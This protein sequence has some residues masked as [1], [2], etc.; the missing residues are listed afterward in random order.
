MN[1]IHPTLHRVLAGHF[2]LHVERTQIDDLPR[3]VVPATA[4]LY[5][6]SVWVA[7]VEGEVTVYREDSVIVID[8]YEIVGQH[9]GHQTKIGCGRKSHALSYLDITDDEALSHLIAGAFMALEK[10]QDFVRRADA[11]LVE[12]EREW[13]AA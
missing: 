1:Y 7:D 3:A 8:D 11:A 12:I 10:D 4:E 13:V 5:I 6:G 9:S 2:P